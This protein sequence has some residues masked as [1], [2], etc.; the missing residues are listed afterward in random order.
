[1]T[2]T[3]EMPLV[4]IEGLHKYYGHHHVLRGID[5]TVKQG[6]VSVVIGP[7]GS[8][9]STMLRCVNL[10]ETISAGRISVGGQLIGY[11]EVNGRLHDL[12]TKEIAAQRREIGMVFQRFNLFPHKTALQNVMEAPI[13]VK[14]QSKSEAQKRALEL[15]DRV[16]LGDRSGH[17]PSQLSGGQ[18]Q[19]VAIAR[20]LAMEPE[21]MLFDEP[22]SAL[23]PELVGDV[24]NVMKDLAKSGMTMIVVTHEIGFAREVGDTLTFMD[25]GVVVES[26]DPREIIAN[27]QH[28]RTKEF[29]GRVL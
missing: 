8:G 14:G 26:G 23:D 6:E 11:R 17:Y 2:V 21:L 29:L 4:K 7:S 10:L 5:M 28:A 22:T 13:H 16:G 24:L 1:M 15:L 27:P 12:K 18:Q 9:K 20:A 3:A 25:G 19:R